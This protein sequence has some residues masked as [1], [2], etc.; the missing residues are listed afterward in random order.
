[1]FLHF[2]VLVGAQKIN[3]RNTEEENKHLEEKRD[4]ERERVAEKR[5]SRKERE[6]IQ[7]GRVRDVE[8]EL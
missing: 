3:L 6:E 7:T 1:M 4:R 5:E 8:R 2:C